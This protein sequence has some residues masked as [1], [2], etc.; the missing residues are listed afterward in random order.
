MYCSPYSMPLLE[1]L[2]GCSF[3]G[4]FVDLLKL[5]FSA[6]STSLPI[7][8]A[9]SWLMSHVT[10]LTSALGD[11]SW[12]AFTH[13]SFYS[14]LCLIMSKFPLSCMHCSIAFCIH[15]ASI[16]FAQL[17]ICLFVMSLHFCFMANSFIIYAV[18]ISS[19]IPFRNC[20]F[21]CLSCSL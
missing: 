19:F 2:F 17:R 3:G 11:V 16:F 12:T 20:P 15:C 8:G 10:V 9:S 21:N 6:S 4:V 18:I 7:G 1:F 5:C 13:V 14:F